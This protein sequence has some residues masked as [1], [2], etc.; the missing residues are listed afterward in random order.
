MNT[1]TLDERLAAA[2]A[3]A[4]RISAELEEDKQLLIGL[5]KALTA[6]VRAAIFQAWIT[7]V[8]IVAVSIILLAVVIR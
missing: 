3:E 8:A 5:R 6:P 1:K 7:W 2:Q 4:E